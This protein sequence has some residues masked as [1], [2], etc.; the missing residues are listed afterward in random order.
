VLPAA[1]SYVVLEPA[2]FPFGVAVLSAPD[3]TLAVLLP[4]FGL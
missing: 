4:V 1:A 2:G 3:Y